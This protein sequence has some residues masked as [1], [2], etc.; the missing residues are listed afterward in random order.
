M[1]M[2]R[3]VTLRVWTQV[4]HGLG[5]NWGNSLHFRAATPWVRSEVNRICMLYYAHHN[6]AMLLCMHKFPTRASA[7][8]SVEQAWVR[9][10]ALVAPLPHTFS[11]DTPKLKGYVSCILYVCQ[12]LD[13]FQ[14]RNLWK[15]SKK[16]NS[17]F[18]WPHVF[19]HF[20]RFVSTNRKQKITALIW[21][22]N[23]NVNFSRFI[24]YFVCLF[25][26][27]ITPYDHCSMSRMSI[28]VAKKG[29]CTDPTMD[30]SPHAPGEMSFHSH[31]TSNHLER[32]PSL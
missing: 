9:D 32:I 23:T 4:H 7:R 17:I 28:L 18:F 1:Y 21:A 16:R 19:I 10:L 20:K 27:F 31:T 2:T 6:E 25:T 15:I 29:R 12:V 30:L 14:L 24:A 8:T 3:F 22:K 13:S 26:M 5:G 11:L